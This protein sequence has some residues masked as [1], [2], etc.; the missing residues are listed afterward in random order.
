MFRRVRQ[1]AAAGA[2]SAISDC[3]VCHL[4]REVSEAWL[5][6][7]CEWDYV[8]LTTVRSMQPSSVEEAPSLR[9]QRQHLGF[10]TNE[11]QINVAL[12]RARK[13]LIII[14][15]HIQHLQNPL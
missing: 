11:H 5:C 2:K 14:G 7:G 1:V 3:V 9:W 10:I 15:L 8:V 6:S 4:Q 12:T 13:G